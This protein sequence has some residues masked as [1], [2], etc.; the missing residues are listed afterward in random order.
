M[1]MC[2]QQGKINNVLSLSKARP[3]GCEI[4]R[5]PAHTGNEIKQRKR[6]KKRSF[7]PYGTW[8]RQ[9]AV[10]VQAYIV[11]MCVGSNLLCF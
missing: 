2:G 1:C 9:V 3:R 5:N 8:L 7:T 4:S 6:E 11:R 10:H